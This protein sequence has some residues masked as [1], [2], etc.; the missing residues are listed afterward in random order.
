MG[1]LDRLAPRKSEPEAR[2][3]GPSSGGTDDPVFATKALVR[4]GFPAAM[5]A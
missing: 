4:D 1:L 3:R 2:P 5:E